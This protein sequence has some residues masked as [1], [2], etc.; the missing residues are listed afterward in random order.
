VVSGSRTWQA[1]LLTHEISPK[2]LTTH[3]NLYVEDKLAPICA[4]EDDRAPMNG[5]NTR[6]NGGCHEDYELCALSFSF[7]WNLVGKIAKYLTSARAKHAEG[8]HQTRPL[9]RKNADTASR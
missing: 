4:I 2:L 3:V 8:A 5:D 9:P 1:C 7:F 6:M